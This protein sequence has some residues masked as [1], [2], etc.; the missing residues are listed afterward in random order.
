MIARPVQL[1]DP[2]A[3]WGAL[4]DDQREILSYA[5]HAARQEGGEVYLVGGPVRDLLHGAT[6]L[7]DI[8]L[9]TT[10]DARRVAERLAASMDAT[11]VKTTEF[12]TATIEVRDSG[13][14]RS[15]DIATTRTETY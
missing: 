10:V 15:I 14:T 6:R 9:T 2:A 1:P 12:G 11:V 5:A 13:G 7:R 8:D 4:S 3:L